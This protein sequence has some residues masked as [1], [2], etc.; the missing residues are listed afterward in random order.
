MC[1]TRVPDHTN[2]VVAPDNLACLVCLQH[3]GA[4]GWSPD[5]SVYEP[6]V[7]LMNIIFHVLIFIDSLSFSCILII[8]KQET[9]KKNEY[10][11]NQQNI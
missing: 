5:F 4:T 8:H 3:K 10:I 11:H 7:V 9:N 6:F 2:I 1:M